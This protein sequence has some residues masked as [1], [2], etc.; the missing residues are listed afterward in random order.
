MEESQRYVLVGA[1][2]LIT[3][4]L[5]A[6][7]G[8]LGED[9]GP[10]TTVLRCNGT[11][12]ACYE[13][14]ISQRP[15]DC[16]EWYP[17]TPL[18][19][20]D[21]SMTET[22]VAEVTYVTD[23]AN[24]IQA[25][26]TDSPPEAELT[27]YGLRNTFDMEFLPGGSMLLTEKDGTLNRVE[28]GEATAIAS[29]DVYNRET[30]GLMGLAVH[31]NFT[32]NRYVYLYYTTGED[33]YPTI[34]KSGVTTFVTNEIARFRLVDGELRDRTVLLD[35]I[36]GSIYHNGGR[37]EFG[38]DG[39]LYAGIGEGGLPRYGQSHD[40][41]HGTILRM[42]PDGSVPS[43]NPFDNRVYA[44]GFKNP[45]GL[46]WHPRTGELYVTDHGNW[47]HDEVNRVRPGASYGWGAVS[48]DEPTGF[49]APIPGDPR[50]PLIC[51]REFTLAPTSIVFVESGPWQ[52]ELFLASLRGKQIHRFRLEDGAITDNEIFWINRGVPTENGLS[53]RMRDVEFRNGTLWALSDWGGVV[54]LRPDTDA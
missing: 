8:L 29:F 54:E 50:E 23:P 12:T 43:D 42:N 1:A 40:R 27:S 48:C 33:S 35:D 39:K 13:D 2:V 18:D 11:E 26:F 21:C 52:G 30:T 24:Y 41:I 46:D 5:V 22:D 31:P 15:T 38:P 44:T 53:R 20:L 7:I 4:G 28:G 36:P 34:N 25:S 51:F 14:T 32:A 17:G 3:V 19:Q 49:V 10:S 16:N 45:Q 37:L 47:R 9:A 6:S